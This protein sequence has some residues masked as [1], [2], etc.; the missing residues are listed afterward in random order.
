MKTNRQV[1]QSIVMA[2]CLATLT[3]NG[4]HAKPGGVGEF[5]IPAVVPLTEAQ[6]Q[7][8]AEQIEAEPRAAVLALTQVE[9]AR[10]VLDREPQPLEVIHYEGL[11]NTDF[12][13]IETVA[14]LDQMADA[15]MVLRAWQVSGEPAFAA[16][17]QE[18]IVAW[19]DTY[20]P[21]GN[22][23]NE[24]KLY[25]LLVAYLALRDK[26]DPDTQQRV[27]AWVREIGQGHLDQAKKSNHL[28]NR[29]T[30]SLR[31]VAIT[32]RILG[33]SSWVDTARDGAQRFISQSLYADGRSKDLEHRDSLGYHMSALRP[34]VQLSIVLDGADDEALYYWQSPSGSS[35]E[36]SVLFVVPY[37]SG[38]K[39][40]EEWTDTKVG[41]DRRRAEAGLE[42]YEAGRL[43]EPKDAVKLLSE[44]VFYEPQL[45][46]LLAEL[47]GAEDTDLPTFEVMVLRVA[48]ASPIE[49]VR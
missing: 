16:Y 38:E 21:T 22:D 45:L 20:Q 48:G 5:H 2:F 36:R 15:A 32:G 17:L 47:T 6:R 37:A 27:D 25:P 26:F 29:Y 35:I 28:T 14:K 9:A 8:L 13:R 49:A 10:R 24:N 1:F 4:V 44:A 3:T 46:P 39:Q 31:L 33:E 19:A 12:K 23:V 7:R 41:L 11:L 30:K 42:K 40:R 34:L 43:F 18:L